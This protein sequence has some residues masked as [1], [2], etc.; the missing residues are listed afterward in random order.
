MLRGLEESNLRPGDT[1]AVIGLGPIG[2]MFVRLAKAV[3]GARVIAIGRRQPQL[4]RAAR[5]GADELIV[6]TDGADV[7][8]AVKAMTEGRGAD[9]V[10][11]AVG[12]PEL[13]QLATRLLRRGGVV[14]FFGGCA[15]GTEVNLDTHLLHYSEITCKASFHHTPGADSQS[16]RSDW[17][18]L[19]H[20]QG[21]GEWRRAAGQSAGSDAA[22][23]EPQRPPE[24]GHHPLIAPEPIV[25]LGPTAFLNDPDQMQRAWPREEALAY[26]HWLATHHYENFQVVSFLLPK[27]LHQDFYNVYAFC[28]WSD[29]LGDEIG[30]PQESLRLLAWWRGELQA[31]YAGRASH[32]VFVALQATVADHHLPMEPFDH[33]IQAFEQDQ[34]V[35]RY[36]NFDELFKYCRY[37]ANPV[38]RLVLGLCGYQDAE[39]QALSDATCTALQLAN[40]WQDVI[41]DLQKDRV[42]LPLDVLERNGYPVEDLFARRFDDRFR[43]AMKEVV[44]VA[45]ELFLKGLPLAGQ[46]DRRLAIDLELFS[47]GG[48]KILEKIERQDYDVLRAAR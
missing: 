10:I 20:G 32:P 46:V 8:G 35:T 38:G 27:R 5:M 11:E 18:R 40:F 2:I 4:D 33:L 41:V 26:T 34:T 47:R 13:W 25:F 9:V 3:Y 42:Y 6:N 30:D 1:V 39:R 48:L 28:R 29:D 23:D 12:L 16:A 14:N 37:S 19:C 44:G 21:S 7:V 22:S 43:R 36:R 31:M 24:D 45:R 15:T 17:P